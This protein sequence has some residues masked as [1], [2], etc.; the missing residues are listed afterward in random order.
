[1]GEKIN[2]KTVTLSE[3]NNVGGLTLPDFRLNYEA[4]V[5]KC[6]ISERI[7]KGQTT[8]LEDMSE[9]YMSDQNLLSKIHK[10]L[11]NSII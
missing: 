7:D 2:R 6:D 9:K 3:N 4:T 8:N 5:I 10:E 11:L 1:M